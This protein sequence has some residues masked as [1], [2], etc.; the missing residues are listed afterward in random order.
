[1]SKT[2]YPTY[3]ACPISVRFENELTNTRM[4]SISCITVRIFLSALIIY[5]IYTYI[6]LYTYLKVKSLTYI[7]KYLYRIVFKNKML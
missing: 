2:K 5:N 1:M 4:R 6:Y 3:I 7:L